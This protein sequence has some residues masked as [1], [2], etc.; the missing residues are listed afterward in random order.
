[1]FCIFLI[2]R[3]S[4]LKKYVGICWNKVSRQYMPIFIEIA[5]RTFKILRFESNIPENENHKRRH[6]SN[7]EKRMKAVINL[8]TPFH[9]KSTRKSVRIL[10]NNIFEK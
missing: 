6:F 2:N 3:L 5:S 9:F 4:N 8:I 1:M 7:R 10:Q